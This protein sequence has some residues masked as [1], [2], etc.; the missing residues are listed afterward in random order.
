M[1]IRV[2]LWLFLHGVRPTMAVTSQP[3]GSLGRVG[4]FAVPVVALVVLAGV[5]IWWQWLR[6]GPQAPKPPDEIPLG[7][8]AKIPVPKVRFSDVTE[9]AGIR[10]VHTNGS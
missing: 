9:Q 3:R 10:F 2:H 7:S 4:L 6:P 8:R 1:F 5:G